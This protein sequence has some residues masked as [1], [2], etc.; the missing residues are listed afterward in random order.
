MVSLLALVICICGCSYD[1][2]NWF[3]VYR[4]QDGVRLVLEPG[5]DAVFYNEVPGIER[6]NCSYVV[7]DGYLKFLSPDWVK[8]TFQIS[9]QGLVDPRGLKWEKVREALISIQ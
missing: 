7:E 6:T 9:N 8:V 4:N 5:G 1:G 2:Y 3:G